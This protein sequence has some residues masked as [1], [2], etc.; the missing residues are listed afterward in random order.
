MELARNPM[1]LGSRARLFSNRVELPLLCIANLVSLS[2]LFAW[3]TL[4]K[5]HLV[6]H[7]S[8]PPYGLTIEERNISKSRFPSK[9][10]FCAL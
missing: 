9:S 1:P 6:Q 8:K 2:P 10:N 5:T 7:N 3:T 4:S